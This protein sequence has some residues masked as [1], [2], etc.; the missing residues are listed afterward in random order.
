LAP[1]YR[2]HYDPLRN[3][4]LKLIAAFYGVMIGFVATRT[5]HDAAPFVMVLCDGA[6]AGMDVATNQ[7]LFGQLPSNKLLLVSAWIEIHREELVASWNA[8]RLTGDY[9]KLDPLR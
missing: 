5:R 2:R 6:E 4:D 1:L 8:G 7:L 3:G 9:F